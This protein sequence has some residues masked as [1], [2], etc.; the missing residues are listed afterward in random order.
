MWHDG[1]R[2]Q[3][4]HDGARNL[5][6][7]G[8]GPPH[9]RDGARR[10]RAKGVSSATAFRLGL[11]AGW[12]MAPLFGVV[13][14]LR[15]ARTFHPRGVTYHAEVRARP[16]VAED[17]RG[18]AARLVGHA[19]VR[20][21]GALWKEE[22]RIPDVLGCAIRIRNDALA[23]AT[24][25]DSDQDLLFATIRRPWTMPF[26]PFATNTRDFLANDYF[27]VSPFD[28]GVGHD[29]YF[30]LH[31]DHACRHHGSRMHRLARE[32]ATRRTALA[33]EVARSPFGPWSPIAD[34]VLIRPAGVD[35]DALRFRP[36]RGGRGIHPRGFVHAL[37][38]GV[39]AGSQRL[40]PARTL[41]RAA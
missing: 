39:Y 1:A 35:D 19:L 21:S 29:V 17:L 25:A 34:V 23:T 2:R 18:L 31:P 6:Q 41:H 27:A 5:A 22:E 4:R 30:R 9:A 33:L 38:V 20:F 24:P 26:A 14:A 12:G 7:M 11:V 10:A 13:S 37:R 16:D 28:A 8:R 15:R 32:V 36:F 40:R 3:N